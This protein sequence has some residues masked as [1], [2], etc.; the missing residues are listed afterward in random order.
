M[1]INDVVETNTH[2]YFWGSIFSNFY[3]TMFQ[4][5][6]IKVNTSEQ[7]FMLA[8]AVTFNDKS[9]AKLIADSRTP[10]EA[11]KLGRLVKNYNDNIWDSKRYQ[12]MVEVLKE[13]F[14][15]PELKK[16]LLSTKDKILVEGSP[17][18]KIWGVGLHYK[19]EKIKDE[20]NWKGQNLLGKALM[21][22]RDFYE[23]ELS[24]N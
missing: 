10:Q 2:I 15:N 21:E 12:I 1:K 22:V 18:D 8:K 9:T 23:D 6:G 14:N 5:K 16:A 24:R 7:A 20:K 17:Y 3:Y 11:K 13:K 19:D 4:Y